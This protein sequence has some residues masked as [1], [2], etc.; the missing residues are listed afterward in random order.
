MSYIIA[1]AGKG[2]TG[3]TTI[4]AL[5]ARLLKENNCGPVLAV[6]AD[7]NS[8]LAEALGLTQATTIGSI[9]DEVA[10]H[11]EN[12]PAGMTK[13]RFV[14]YRVQSAVTEGDGIDCLSM[15]RSEGPGCYCY[16]NNVL[17]GVM[18]DLIRD[19]RYVIIDNEAGLEHLSRRTTRR[20]DALIVVAD[21]TSA[22][23]KA[24]SRIAELAR[25]LKIDI[26]KS[27]LIINR[28]DLCRGGFQT[29]PYSKI[30]VTGLDFLGCL[31][32]DEAVE[33][34]SRNG[35]TLMELLDSAPVMGALRQ[36]GEKIWFC[37]Q[38]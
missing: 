38:Q 28:E 33:K 27:W 34:I 3:K 19:Y 10:A 14:E 7:P 11:P 17:R 5:L 35:G 1:L 9:V 26:K 32:Y 18:E 15:G 31:P 8:N 30:Q 24:A 16:V 25:E 4:A 6:D 23:L 13:D 21:A 36:L 2:G 37:S 22:G 20:A 12:I 29:R